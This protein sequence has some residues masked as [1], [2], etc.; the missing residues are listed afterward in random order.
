MH[1]EPN[2]P[3]RW[4][5]VTPDQVGS[6]LSGA[7]PPDL[8]FLEHLVACAG[9]VVARS[10][11]GDLFFVGRSLDSM[12][13]LISGAF[14]GRRAVRRLPLSFAR[15]RV[16]T[17]PR[18]RQRPLTPGEQAQLRRIMGTLDLTPRALARRARP[19]TFVDV[20]AEGRT[21]SELF[22]LLRDWTDEDRE[23]WS[24]IRRKLHFIGVTAQEKT[25]PNTYRWQQ[26]APWTTQLPAKSVINVSLHWMVWG[27]LAGNQIKLTRTF[28][29]D[30][31]LAEA[32]GPERGE[33]T[34]EAL[35]EA[36][37]LV[38]YGR[39]R[40]GRQALA[41]VIVEEPTMSQSWLRAVVTLLNGG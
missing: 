29:P 38:A 30:R 14:D 24:V 35:A 4:D 6:L 26:H 18:S 34:R 31:W 36:A 7:A 11:D 10:G 21:F 27:Y 39:S 2:L 16:G 19:A 32:A 37:A 12:F 8:W 5:L 23:P 17:P 33:Q 25:S 20:V 15:E 40:T 9:K 22:T 28:R 13:D 3:F 41:R 1:G